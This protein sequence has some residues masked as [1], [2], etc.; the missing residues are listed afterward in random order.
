MKR[1][2]MRRGEIG[3]IVDKAFREHMPGQWIPSHRRAARPVIGPPF[4]GVAVRTQLVTESQGAGPGDLVKLSPLPVDRMTAGELL[5]T[6][7]APGE[8]LFVGGPYDTHVLPVEKLTQ[9]PERLANA[10]HIIPN[11]LT[12]RRHETKSGKLSTRCDAAVKAYRFAVVEFDDVTKAEQYAF[13]LTVIRRELLPVTALI[14]SGRK[15]IHAWL[16]V[17]LPD[18]DAWGS[19]VGHKLYDKYTGML[20]LLGADPACKNPSR[21]SR[22]PFHV[23][24]ETGAVQ[25]LLYLRV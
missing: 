16:R 6:L 25:R 20:T 15:S 21:L 2:Q 3:E 22:M 11:P 8:C 23:R 5:Y 17:D 13:W 24:K 19:Q 18:R 14:D 4:D 10:P 1:Q 9:H 7:Y 12:G